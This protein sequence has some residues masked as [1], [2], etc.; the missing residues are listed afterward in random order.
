VEVAVAGAEVLVRSSV[1][2]QARITLTRDEWEE[3]LAGVKEGLFDR[4]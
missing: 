3:F 2:P 1:T 4:V